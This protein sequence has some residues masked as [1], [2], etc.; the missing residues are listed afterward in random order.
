[1]IPQRRT[2]G[3][4]NPVRHPQRRGRRLDQSREPCYVSRQFERKEEGR[5]HPAVELLNE[6]L[7]DDSGYDEAVWPEVKQALDEDR[8]S[9]R[10]LFE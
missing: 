2:P 10:K 6:W 7:H 1:M 8:L 4:G 5:E 9:N 3:G